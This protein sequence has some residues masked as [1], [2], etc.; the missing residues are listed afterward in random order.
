MVISV[1]PRASFSLAM[2]RRIKQVGPV[3]PYEPIDS[4]LLVKQIPFLC[5]GLGRRHFK[6]SG[7]MAPNT[8]QI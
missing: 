6:S 3:K 1:V 4:T 8:D 7:M 2:L 5:H